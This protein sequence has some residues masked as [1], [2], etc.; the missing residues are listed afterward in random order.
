MK[1]VD[2]KKLGVLKYGDF[3]KAVGIKD[4]D[5][6]T[7]QQRFIEYVKCLYGL[8]ES[9]ELNFEAARQRIYFL[10]HPEWNKPK[11]KQYYKGNKETI[12]IRQHEYHQKNRERIN[13]WKKEY[14][15]NNH[16]RVLATEARYRAKKKE[17]RLRYEREN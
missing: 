11:C 2:V 3:C 7:K 13:A 4:K 10:R 12:A 15:K 6:D 14:R 1:N 8:D 16:E 5:T 17:E 9:F